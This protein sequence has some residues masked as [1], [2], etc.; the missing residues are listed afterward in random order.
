[1]CPCFVGKITIQA[2]QSRIVETIGIQYSKET[3]ISRER[4]EI[5]N[6]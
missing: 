5:E 2:Q 4:V 6:E 1:M 3:D